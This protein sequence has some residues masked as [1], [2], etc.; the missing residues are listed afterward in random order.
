[1]NT[2]DDHIPTQEEID[3][4]NQHKARTKANTNAYFQGDPNAVAQA[5]DA[6]AQDQLSMFR[7]L[8]DFLGFGS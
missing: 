3:A 8:K 1:M 4:Y 7:K 6:R 2:Q 5:G